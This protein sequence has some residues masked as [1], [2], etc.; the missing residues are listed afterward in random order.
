MVDSK[1]G[2]KGNLNPFLG[3]RLKKTWRLP[4]QFKKEVSMSIITDEF[5]KLF[6]KYPIRSQE[7]VKDPKV[8]AKLFDIAGAGTWF[9]TEF[10]AETKIAF[11]YV[12]G[13][14][15]NEWGDIYIPELECIHHNELR[16]RLALLYIGYREYAVIQLRKPDP[17]HYASL[18]LGTL[19]CKLNY[20][21]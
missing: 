14:G 13:L 15:C 17:R 4:E 18:T 8:I 6:Q 5:V 3:I 20:I 16:V 11:G 10:D 21:S 9:L 12:V 19:T 7:K 2:Q 1:L